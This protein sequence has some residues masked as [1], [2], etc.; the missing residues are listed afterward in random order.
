VLRASLL[1]VRKDLRLRTRD[2]SVLLI[3]F[4]VPLGLTALFS[5][6]F[7]SE[8]ELEIRGAVVDLDGGPVGAGLADDLL[9]ALVDQGV[10]LSVDRLDEAEARSQV[11]DGELAVA[12]V[13]PVGTSQSITTG[14]GATIEVLVADGR[15]LSGEV[16][17]GV[18]RAYAAEID[19]IGLAVVTAAAATGSPPDGALTQQVAAMAATVAPVASVMDATTGSGQRMDM[20]SYLAAGMAA[21][22]VFFTVQFG[23]SGLLEERELG[24]LPR[25]LASPIP[26][27]AVQAGK[28][29]GAFALGLVSMTVLAVASSLLLGASWGPTSGV[30]LLI[31][32]LVIA[33]LGVMALVGSFAKTAEQAGNLQSIVAVVLGLLGGVFF[34]LPG[35]NLLLRTLTGVSPHGWFLRGLQD[36]VASG[37]WT[38]VLP[39]VAAIAAFGFAAAVPAMVLL[40]RRSTW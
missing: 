34:P 1:L 19:R 8:G 32:A 22:F 39:N 4:V 2:R 29:L 10:L 21:F 25:L 27:A 18:A 9:P 36:L 3:A 13:V 16:A 12:W 23:V 28:L 6:I 17:R 35:D 5:F 31:V 24:T 26:P 14:A 37:D 38:V 40:R 11:T 30:A 15:V 7:P 20:T 33:A